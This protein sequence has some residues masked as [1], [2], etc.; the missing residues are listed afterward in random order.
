MNISKQQ[1]GQMLRQM[2]RVRHLEENL[3]QRYLAKQVPGMSPHLSV[4]PSPAVTIDT[5]VQ[6]AYKE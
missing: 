2:L 1:H 6:N 3:Y 5:V 4:R